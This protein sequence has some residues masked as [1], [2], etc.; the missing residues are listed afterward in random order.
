M[1]VND[2]MATH[3]LDKDQ[4][5]ATFNDF[6]RRGYRQVKISA[7]DDRGTPRYASLWYR[8]DGNEWLAQHG[9]D[10]AEFLQSFEL[11]GQDNFRPVDL[12]VVRSGGETRF[13]V[14]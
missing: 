4:H 10:E 5:Q 13:S 3:A 8:Q 12:S 9:M 11:N 1:I 7:Y 14:I 2:W 6:Y